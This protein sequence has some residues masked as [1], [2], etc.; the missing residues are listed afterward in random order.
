MPDRPELEGRA[1]LKHRQAQAQANMAVPMPSAALSEA[2]ALPPDQR[3][4]RL[5]EQPLR[6]E[7]LRLETALDQRLGAGDRRAI[8]RGDWDTLTASLGVKSEL[9]QEVAGLAK[10]V[11]A[12]RDAIRSHEQ[13]LNRSRSGPSLGR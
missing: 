13:E 1:L 9:A 10:Q 8:A 11:S 7:L 6:K 2:L 5:A 12:G 3:G 4:P